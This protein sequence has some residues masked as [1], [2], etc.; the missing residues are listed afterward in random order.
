MMLDLSGR[1]VVIIG[2]GAVA[3][4]K[5]AGVLAAGAM[6]VKVV[7]PQITDAMPTAVERILEGYA[8]RHLAGAGLV[9]AATNSPEVNAAVV[10][11]A[12]ELGILVNR[13][14]SSEDDGGDFSTPALLRED[15]LLITVSA[16][17]NP[18]LAA[19]IRD[20]IKNA[21]DARWSKMAAAMKVLRPQV[22]REV[23]DEKTRRT[24]LR[25]L[26]SADALDVLDHDGV[27]GL[28]TWLT[29]RHLKQG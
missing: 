22:L 18:A 21:L 16:G 25:E 29:E 15:E 20:E 10:R 27:E 2:G 13:A 5:A 7:A 9:F 17:G 8:P 11:D 1:L 23:A 3:L 19:V 28:W 6:R 14:D 12:H 4:R 24:I 26:A